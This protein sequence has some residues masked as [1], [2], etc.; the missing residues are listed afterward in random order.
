MASAARLLKSGQH[1]LGHA[2]TY[3]TATSK[4]CQTCQLSHVRKFSISV[5]MAGIFEPDDLKLEPDIPEYTSLN[6]RIR[7]YDFVSLESY[8]K[9]VHRMANHLDL[10]TTAWAV[11]ARYL[12]IRTFKPNS[13]VVDNKYSLRLFERTV[14]IDNVPSPSLSILLEMMRTH[15]PEGIYVT[16]KEPDAEE[17]EFRYIPDKEM[18][19]LKSQIK[20]IDDARE[21]RRKK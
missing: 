6:L 11:P 19:E 14:Q 9:H 4:I 20:A 7:G 16:V 15:A 3:V 17:E 12:D 10:D 18:Q 21:E 8:A 5:P 2:Q 13:S 1:L